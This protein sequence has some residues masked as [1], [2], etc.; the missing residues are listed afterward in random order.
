MGDVFYLCKRSHL[1]Y[2]SLFYFINDKRSYNV[3]NI[4]HHFEDGHVKLDL[5]EAS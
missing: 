3:V 5:F 1:L 2:V 4:L